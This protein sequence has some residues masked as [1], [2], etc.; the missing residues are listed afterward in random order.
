MG[1]RVKRS[2]LGSRLFTAVGMARLWL[3]VFSIFEGY[4]VQNLF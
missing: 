1:L 3:Q 2:V 4:S